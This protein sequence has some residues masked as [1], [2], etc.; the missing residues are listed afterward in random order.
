MVSLNDYDGDW[1][2][3]L[4]FLYALFKR[5][6]LD[7]APQFK[8]PVR[9]KFFPEVDHPKYKHAT[10]WHLISEGKIES[11]RVPALDRCERLGWIRPVIERYRSS[12]VRAWEEIR[13]GQGRGIEP[14]IHIALNDFSYLVVLSERHDYVLLW[15]AYP[16]NEQHSRRKLMNRFAQAEKKLGPP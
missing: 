3:F 6:F 11:E 10:F 1:E 16:I 7:G 12:D 2:K 4:D 13:H 14:R 5:D 8:K 9:T 15:T